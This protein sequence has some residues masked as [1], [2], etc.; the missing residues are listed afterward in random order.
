MP[1]TRLKISNGLVFWFKQF[2]NQ[3]VKKYSWTQIGIV[4]GGIRDC[5]DPD[6][7][8]LYIRLDD[9]E[10]LNFIFEKT[11]RETETQK[12]LSNCFTF[13]I[14]T[15]FYQGQSKQQQQIHSIFHLRLLVKILANSNTISRLRSTLFLKIDC[16]ETHIFMKT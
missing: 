5:G 1:K 2:Q 9:A 15:Q 3:F 12:G 13:F 4:Q 7:P 16:L 14:G 10:V 6:Y 11:G 8:G